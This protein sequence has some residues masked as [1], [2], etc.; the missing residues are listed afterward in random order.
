MWRSRNGRTE[1][2][3]QG[4]HIILWR[5]YGMLHFRHFRL[6]VFDCLGQPAKP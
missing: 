2:F 5:A 1:G 4:L 6:R 3:N